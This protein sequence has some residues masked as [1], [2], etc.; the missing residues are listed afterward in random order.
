MA[1]NN[2]T[3]SAEWSGT[4]KL[5]YYNYQSVTKNKKI[6][7]IYRVYV[8][9]NKNHDDVKMFTHKTIFNSTS[10]QN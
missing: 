2:S 7:Y 10:K 9:V 5:N 1:N 6:V 4:I 8:G 3:N